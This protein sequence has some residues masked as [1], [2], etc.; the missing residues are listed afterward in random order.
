MTAVLAVYVGSG[1][2]TVL[3][4]SIATYAPPV[5][6]GEKQLSN[7]LQDDWKIVD[8]LRIRET[9]VLRLTK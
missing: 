8:S 5:R 9:L 4:C 7:W 6:T 1:V 3:G 2:V